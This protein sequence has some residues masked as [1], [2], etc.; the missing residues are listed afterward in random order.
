MQYDFLAN[1]VAYQSWRDEKLNNYPRLVEN[2]IKPINTPI[3]LTN[4]ERFSLLKQCEKTNFVIYKITIDGFDN[5]STVTCLAKQLGLTQRDANLCAD[6]D[7]ISAIQDIGSG[8]ARYIPY[9]NKK[10]NWHTDGYYN[11]GEKCIR[12]FLMHCVRPAA[13]GGENSFLDPEIAYILLRD[14]DPKYIEALMDPEAMTIPANIEAGVQIR[15]T[16]S[17][18]VFFIDAQTQTLS[19]RY[20]ARQKN[21]VW[22]KDRSVQRAL[23]YLDEILKANPYIFHYRFNAGEGVICNNVLHNRTAFSDF[24]NKDNSRLLYRARFYNRVS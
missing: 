4:E 13:Q 20:T 16:Q 12:A 15:P 3:S 22:K 10:L 11:T 19:M 18:P 7:R 5:K 1:K 8:E 21:I 2:I 14:E 23:S 24:G 6:R 9:T 17:G